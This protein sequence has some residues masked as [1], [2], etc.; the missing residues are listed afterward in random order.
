MG[1]TP[2]N[3]AAS[4]GDESLEPST[5]AAITS[6]NTLISQRGGVKKTNYG[7]PLTMQS[8]NIFIRAA[9]CPLGAIRAAASSPPAVIGP[10]PRPVEPAASAAGVG[11]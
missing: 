4:P 9:I 6:D 7:Q 10:G 11:S 2:P 1:C 8:I 3:G 5:G